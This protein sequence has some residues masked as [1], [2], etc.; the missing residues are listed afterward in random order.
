SLRTPAFPSPLVA[1]PP[2]SV[3][4]DGQRSDRS[5]WHRMA[6]IRVSF[7]PVR[8]RLR[9]GAEATAHRWAVVHLPAAVACQRAQVTGC[10]VCS[11]FAQ[12]SHYPFSAESKEAR[13]R[14]SRGRL[15]PRQRIDPILRIVYEKLRRDSSYRPELPGWVS[16]RADRA[17][18]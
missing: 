16:A 1:F 2:S 12:P 18:A 9:S 17:P 7:T 6:D 13:G 5:L 3:G 10:T 4:A 8:C 11:S 15:L 14:L